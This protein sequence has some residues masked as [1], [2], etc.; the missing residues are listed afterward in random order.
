MPERRFRPEHAVRNRHRIP[1]PIP[2]TSGFVPVHIIADA[3][4]HVLAL[5]LHRNACG[6]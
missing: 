4:S 2:G 3:L 1:P 6:K 5:A